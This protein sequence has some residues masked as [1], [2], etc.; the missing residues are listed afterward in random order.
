MLESINLN[1][2]TYTELLEEAVSQI[3]LFGGE[4][5]NF[6]VSDPGMTVLQ[7]FTSFQFLQRNAINTVTAEIKLKLLKLLGFHPSD[8]CGATCLFETRETLN[9]PPYY[10][11]NADTLVYETSKIEKHKPWGIATVYSDNGSVCTDIT[12]LL[13]RGMTTGTAVFGAPARAGSYFCCILSGQPDFSKRVSLYARVIDD[14]RRNPFDDGSPAFAELVWQLYTEDGWADLTVHDTTRGL[15]ASGAIDVEPTEHKPAVYT[16]TPEKGYAIRCLLK[17]HSYDFPPRLHSVTANVIRLRQR[18][19][20]AILLKKS[21]RRTVLVNVDMEAYPY[22]YVYARETAG[23]TYREYLP[24]RNED[25]GRFYTAERE[26]DGAARF[27]FDKNRFGFAPMEGKQSVVLVCCT[28]EMA[29]SR[30]L[31]KVYG[32]IDQEIDV[33]EMEN[34]ID[35][36]AMVEYE[37]A[38]GPEFIFVKPGERSAD[39]SYTLNARDGKI[40]IKD[41][42]WGSGCKIYVASCATTAGAR[43]NI[44]EENRFESRGGDVIVNPAPGTGGADA[45]GI[46]ELQRRFAYT[47]KNPESTV[48][49]SDYEDAV[50]STPGLCIHKVRATADKGLVTIAVKPH[51]DS[52]RPQLPPGYI[53]A[54]HKRL[55]RRRMLTTMFKLTQPVYAPIDVR[56]QIYVKSY[57]NNA[58]ESVEAAL[59]AALDQVTGDTGFGE[60]I[61][62]ND[63]FQAVSSLPCVQSVYTL[64]LTPCPGSGAAQNGMDIVPDTNCLCYPGKITLEIN[65]SGVV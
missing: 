65:T 35:F 60:V 64:T 38:D 32:Y 39:F 63:V 58:G 5:T 31:G 42:G 9:L 55:M 2:K 25:R 43:G 53:D 51:A 7:N 48:L 21:G 24:Y 17:S 16:E 61:K 27:A 62:F 33:N 1:D 19:T 23:G 44:K 41:P 29:R 37:S 15:L 14:P 30:F 13:D 26:R 11:F 3:P 22:I 45:A 36:C 54:I 40:V 46:A 28:E 10:K 12:T 20:K 4:W 59:R 8:A 34:I 49:T 50:K 52:E 6:N 57:F 47:M 18:D 56:A